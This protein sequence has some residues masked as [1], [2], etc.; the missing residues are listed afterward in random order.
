MIRVAIVEDEEQYAN[1][2]IAFLQRYEKERGV[3][4]AAD[5][6]ESG[7]NF[8]S[9]YSGCYDVVFMDIK[10]PHMNGMQCAIKLR[11]LDED[12]A[13]IFVTSMN[14]YALKGYEVG[15][16]GYMIKPISYY[17]LAVLMDK[18]QKKIASKDQSDIMI[19]CGDSVK[20]FP[21]RELMYVEVYDHYLLYHTEEGTYR[22]IGRMKTAE[23]ELSPHGFFRCSNSHLVN[24]RFVRAV[25]ENEVTVGSERVPI[26]R[27]RKKELLEALNSYFKNGGAR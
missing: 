18:V 9:D 8:V 2:L 24:L 25:E 14:R 5:C 17:P 13:L 26:S 15:A 16:M 23:E 7:I 4:I 6:F 3:E 21:L 11:E 19:S 12:V 22:E 10:L 27:R 20:R 1:D